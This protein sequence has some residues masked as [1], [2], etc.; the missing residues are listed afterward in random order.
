MEGGHVDPS[1][2]L[3]S[4]AIDVSWQDLPGIIRRGSRIGDGEMLGINRPHDRLRAGNE[5]ARTRVRIDITM[6]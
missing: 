2:Q 5:E 3:N 6:A 4:I 1:H